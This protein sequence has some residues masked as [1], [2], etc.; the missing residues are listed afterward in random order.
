LQNDRKGL[1][2][3]VEAS[4]GDGRAGEEGSLQQAVEKRGRH[5]RKIDGEEEIPFGIGNGESGVDST[6]WALI[7]EGI[8]NFFRE[9]GERIARTGDL[10]WDSGGFQGLEG[11]LDERASG[12]ESQ[13]L[14]SAH[15]GGLAAGKDEA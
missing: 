1:N 15:A 12:E 10:R 7:G 11:D 2:A 13:C 3:T 5:Q 14:I 8:W 9:G 6:E 4:R